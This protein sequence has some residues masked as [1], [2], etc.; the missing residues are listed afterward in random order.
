MSSQNSK[1]LWDRWIDL[2][3]GDLELAQQIIHPDLTI[4]RF[5]PPRIPG[6]LR[7]REALLAWIKQ[8][9]SLFADLRLHVEVGPIVDGEAVAGR[10]VAEGRYAGG[11]PGSTVPVG[12]TLQFHGNDIWRAGGGLIRKYWLSDDLLDLMMQLGV[13]SGR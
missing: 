6:D 7:G 12:T 8:T 9:R 1:V 11:I 13:I 5:P 10:W 3:N 2:W 4:E